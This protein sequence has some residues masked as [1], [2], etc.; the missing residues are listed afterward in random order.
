MTVRRA[1]YYV[2][3]LFRNVV[4]LKGL[5]ALLSSLGVLY[6]VLKCAD[7][8]QLAQQS[9][10]QKFWWVFLAA[11][12]V[13]A[14]WIC[15]PKLTVSD[16]LKDRDIGIEIAIGDLFSFPGAI[17]VGTNS[18][19]DTRIS[20]ELISATSVQGQFMKKYYEDH[21]PLDTELSAGL[22]TTRYE[23]LNDQRSGKKKRYPLGT[24]VKLNPKDRTGYFLAIA[25]VNE[26]GVAAGN[27]EDLKQALGQLWVFIGQRGLKEPL[28]VPVLGSGFTRLKQPRQ[29]IV[30]EILKSF[31]AACSE[32]TFCDKLTIVLGAN[33]VLKHRVDFGALGDYLHHV[34]TYTEFAVNTSDRVG[35]PVT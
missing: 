20:T 35:T 34:C 2:T 31:I 28:V 32:R 25:H 12:A 24:V 13:G 33:D 18:T 30:Q 6:T 1:I 9:D 26:H 23:E 11:G 4:S 17:V 16:K 3:T 14:I 7:Y 10:V 15:R 21:V 27:F 19:F 5:S 22:N 8:F 29:I